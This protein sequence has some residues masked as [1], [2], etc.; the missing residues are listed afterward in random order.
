MHLH[1]VRPK[2][3]VEDIENAACRPNHTFGSPA[4]TSHLKLLPSIDAFGSKL[5]IKSSNVFAS[6]L[7][8]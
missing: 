2:A 4:S 5:S 8:Y 6:I 7:K 3:R 1:N